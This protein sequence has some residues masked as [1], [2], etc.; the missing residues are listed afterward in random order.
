MLMIRLFIGSAF[1]LF[2]TIFFW[3]QTYSHS[4]FSLIFFLII[5]GVISLSFISIKMQERNCFKNCY[6]KESSIFSKM[7]SSRV[8]VTVFYLII[9]ILMSISIVHALVSFSMDILIYLLLHVVLVILI[10]SYLNRLLIHTVKSKY[11][12]ILSREIT[13]T[14]SS[15]F[16]FAV[17]L[18]LSL[19]AYEPVYLQE[20]LTKTIKSAS[21]IMGSDCYYL[22][23][24]LRLKSELDGWMWWMI[25]KSSSTIQN[26][27][28]N[29]IVWIVF[30]IVNAFAIVGIN[31]F[32]VQI[33]YM[34]NEMFANRVEDEQG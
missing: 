24:V 11:L 31:R 25:T 30:M 13:I 22:D 32:I 34:L 10:F 33:V 16:L 5:L 19:Y 18:Y 15:I 17:Y 1:V 4:C 7:L 12:Y 28:V 9:S 27:F 21:N 23:Y 29:V 3:R 8:L 2:L 26:G 6:F 14:I 20:S